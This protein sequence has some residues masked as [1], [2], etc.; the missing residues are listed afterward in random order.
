M[1]TDK[2]PEFGRISQTAIGDEVKKVY[3]IVSPEMTMTFLTAQDR[4][5]YTPAHPPSN[6][7]M[8]ESEI[9]DEQYTML[10][11]ADFAVGFGVN[12]E[13]VDN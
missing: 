10:E 9:S 5:A 13:H 1:L 2:K 6:E 8:C 7:V 12:P 11:T 3:H 4:E